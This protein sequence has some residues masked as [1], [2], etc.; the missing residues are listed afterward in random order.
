MTAEQIKEFFEQHEMPYTQTEDD[1]LWYAEIAARENKF[2]FFVNLDG[3]WIYFTINPFVPTPE[4]DCLDNLCR[5]LARLNYNLTMSKFVI[6]DD[7]DVALT[8]ELPVEGFVYAHFAAAIAALSTAAD[9]SYD[10][11]LTLSQDATAISSYWQM[12]E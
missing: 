4:P 6:D 7:G 2:E 12:D 9:E 1:T 8:V 11:L 10:E 3:E 5:H